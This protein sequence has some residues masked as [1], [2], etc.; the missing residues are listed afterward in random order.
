[1]KRSFS[2]KYQQEELHRAC[3]LGE[4]RAI[5]WIE[6]AGNFSI[7]LAVPGTILDLSTYWSLRK[8]FAIQGD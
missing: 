6:V 2:G 1:L 7:Q 3:L 8:D 5:R 4:E